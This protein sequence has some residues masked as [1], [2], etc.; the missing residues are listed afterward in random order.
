VSVTLAAM[1][2][3]LANGAQ[4]A[5]PP[6]G[7]PVQLAPPNACYSSTAAGGC[8]AFG[9]SLS[10]NGAEAIAI[11]GDGLN[12][13]AGGS[14]G[15][16]AAFSVGAGGALS[17]IGSSGGFADT[18]FATSGA[19]LYAALRDTGS[20]NGAVQAFSRGAGGKLSFVDEVTDGC[21]TGSAH[22]TSNNNGLYDVEG[23]AVAPNGEYVYAASHSGGGG[24]TG[25]R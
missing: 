9:E 20:N 2:A 8:T 11:S 6:V 17:A 14:N 24:T 1:V 3:G 7:M 15:G 23:V 21:A 10:I 16:G 13:Y 22:C 5:P 12:L 18:T 25:G 4:A 19:G